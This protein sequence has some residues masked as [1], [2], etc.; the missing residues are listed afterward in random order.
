[1]LGGVGSA[2]AKPALTRLDVRLNVLSSDLSIMILLCPSRFASRLLYDLSKPGARSCGFSMSTDLWDSDAPR[3]QVNWWV[4]VLSNQVRHRAD[5]EPWTNCLSN[6]AR[7]GASLLEESRSLF[8]IRQPWR[9]VSV[10]WASSAP[11]LGNVF[12]ALKRHAHKTN[13]E[14][15]CSSRQATIPA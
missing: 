6:L 3:S 12:S 4:D 9:F 5:F 8:I 7:R 10:C 15:P 2:G 13:S 11:I 1:M 14:A